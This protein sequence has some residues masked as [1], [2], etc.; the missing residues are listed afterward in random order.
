M[1]KVSEISNRTD[2]WI[3]KD[4]PRK[5]ELIMCTAESAMVHYCIYMPQLTVELVKMS[6]RALPT[7]LLKAEESLSASTL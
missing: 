6:N 7:K 2:T 3:N 5:Q 1:D 4:Q